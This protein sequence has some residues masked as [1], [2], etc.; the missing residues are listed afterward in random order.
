MTTDVLER[1]LNIVAYYASR[2]HQGAVL[3]E[4]EVMFYNQTLAYLTRLERAWEI[5]IELSNREEELKLWRP[6]DDENDGTGSAVPSP[7]PPS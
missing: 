7:P 5:N 1:L 4:D 2:Q 6:D 3:T